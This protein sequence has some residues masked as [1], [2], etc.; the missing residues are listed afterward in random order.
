MMETKKPKKT[1][2]KPIL[3]IHGD[4][5]KVTMENGQF[6]DDGPTGSRM[7]K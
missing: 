5:E 2:S 4:F 1:Y 3:T 7:I 6:G